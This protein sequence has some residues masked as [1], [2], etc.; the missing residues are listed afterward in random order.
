MA[1]PTGAQLQL[2]SHLIW[3]DSWP[4]RSP[5]CGLM[6]HL[7]L[8]YSHHPDQTYDCGI[9]TAGVTT[10]TTIVARMTPPHHHDTF[11]IMS[12]PAPA[13]VRSKLL[14][15]ASC[16][17]DD[18]PF[19]FPSPGT[20]SASLR[21]APPA[22]LKRGYP[23]SLSFIASTHLYPSCSSLPSRRYQMRCRHRPCRACMKH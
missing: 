8:C 14:A 4:R 3:T 1:L 16:R 7:L 23:P 2:T 9:T 20:Q 13:A 21:S 17:P 5:A 10:T 15:L 6:L 22:P 12:A 11:P 18:K 19:S